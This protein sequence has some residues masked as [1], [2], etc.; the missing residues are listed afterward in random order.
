[1]HKKHR[2]ITVLYVFMQLKYSELHIESAINTHKKY[3]S[4]H[5]IEPYTRFD[6]SQGTD[7]VNRN[8][9][10]SIVGIVAH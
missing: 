7:A 9:F 2:F 6:Q 10:G 5:C 1:M 4:A 3:F 8:I